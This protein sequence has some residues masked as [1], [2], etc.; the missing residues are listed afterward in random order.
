[1]KL[2]IV[3]YIKRTPAGRIVWRVVIGLIGGAIT[4]AGSVIQKM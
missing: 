3:Y 1:M 4:V 2:P